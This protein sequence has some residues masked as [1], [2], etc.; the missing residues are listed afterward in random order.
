MLPPRES[1]GEVMLR[2][3]GAGFLL[4]VRWCATTADIRWS[5]TS[6]DQCAL[7]KP[8]EF[9]AAFVF[10]ASACLTFAASSYLSGATNHATGG[11]ITR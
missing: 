3:P 10:L 11:M 2:L 8:S 5:V 1:S 7:G 9:T 4:A 6:R